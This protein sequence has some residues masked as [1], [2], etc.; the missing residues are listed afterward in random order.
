MKNRKRKGMFSYI[1]YKLFIATFAL[2]I[3]GSLMI[4]SASMG[5]TDSDINAIAFSALKQGIFVLVSTVGFFIL[6]KF[7]VARLNQKLIN[8]F[9]IVILFAL[10]STRIFG[11]TGGAYA[12]IKLGSFAS[13]QPSEFAKLF[14]IIYG[15]SL[16]AKN[17]G[18]EQNK[19]NIKKYM[20][21]MSVYAGVVLVWQKDL[22]SA[23]VIAVISFIII[24]IP[25]YKGFRDWSFR[26]MII[27]LAAVA[28]VLLL[29]SPWGTAFLKKFDDHYQ[30][31][32]FLS[33]ANPFEYQYDAGYHLV[34]SLIS[35]ATGGLFGLGYGKSIHK[36]M[37]F[38][39]PT[40]DFILPVVV[41]ELGLVFGFIPIVALYGMLLITLINYTLKSHLTRSRIVY[42]G[43]FT[44]LI[45]HFILNVG[46]VAGLI[47]LTGVPLLFIS[48]G[49]T[50]LL[51]IMCCL[52][53]AES[54][55]I[56]TRRNE[57]ENN[58]RQIQKT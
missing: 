39:N 44:Y 12:W 48:S 15:A 28:G 34:M 42:T 49:G 10:L 45:V 26:L 37:N 52:G 30:I 9:Y 25:D 3:F 18:E 58:I 13:I 27:M 19:R 32:R 8:G 7:P 23:V 6:C 51:S 41:E 33:S 56:A 31:L 17:R 55:I 29:L 57:D 36:Y 1:D 50:S 14:A 24:M 40:T 53:L 20:I 16:F 43:T 47:P 54:E 46:G 35:F 21:M 2:M 11:A 38:P 5:E 22:G 4:I